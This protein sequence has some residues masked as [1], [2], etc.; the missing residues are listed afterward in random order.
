MTEL[1]ERLR[2]LRTDGTRLPRLRRLP[3]FGVRALANVA[4]RVLPRRQR[5]AFQSLHYFLDY[6]DDEQVFDNRQTAAWCAQQGIALPSVYDYLN[7]I[8]SYYWKREAS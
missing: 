2:A 6:L 3:M 7:E 1:M 4:G 8:M 5:R